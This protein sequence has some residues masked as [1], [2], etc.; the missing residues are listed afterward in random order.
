MRQ[1]IVH[2][3]DPERCQ[4][5]DRKVHRKDRGLNCAR[6]QARRATD[7]AHDE[8]IVFQRRA[9]EARRCAH[10]GARQSM[11]TARIRTECV[12]QVG[13][14]KWW[15]EQ[16]AQVHLRAHA[17]VQGANVQLLQRRRFRA[18]LL[19]TLATPPW[20]RRRQASLAPAFQ[21]LLL[22]EKHQPA[23]A[24]ASK[25]AIHRRRAAQSAPALLAIAVR[26]S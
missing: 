6:A 14:Q 18:N 11:T 2:N 15:R 26:Q 1:R 22:S 23:R 9:H 7:S 24:R 21:A 8:P 16:R 20:Q 4:R 13:R 12:G 17:S 10:L 19:R 3:P 25:S 5:G